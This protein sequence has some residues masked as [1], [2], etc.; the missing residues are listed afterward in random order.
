VKKWMKDG[1]I[2]LDHANSMATPGVFKYVLKR[3]DQLQLTTVTILD[4]YPHLGLM[5][6]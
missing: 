1:R 2:M 4:A 3:L 6:Q 5:N